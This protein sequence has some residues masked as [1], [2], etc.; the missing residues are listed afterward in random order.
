MHAEGDGGGGE[1]VSKS[2]VADHEELNIELAEEDDPEPEV[3]EWSLEDVELA[4][5]GL[6]LLILLSNGAGLDVSNFG[7]L[8]E[9]SA[10]DHVEEVHHDEDLEHQ[11]LVHHSV[12][13]NV[14]VLHLGGKEV[15]GDI[16]HG[17][18]TVEH[19]DHDDE[20]VDT[21]GKD[22]AHH[23]LG[24]KLIGGLDTVS[25]DFSGMGVLS[26]ESDSGEHIH[27]K[28]DPEE[29]NNVEG[30]VTEDKGRGENEAHAGE[31]DS[32]LELNELANVVLDVTA[33]TDGGDNGVEVIVHKNDIGMILGGGA[34]ILTH[35]ESDV[36]LRESA[37]VGE[38][39]TGNTDGGVAL[40]ESADEHVLQLGGSSV[41][42]NDVVLHFLKAGL[43]LLVSEGESLTTALFSVFDLN[44]K[45]F[46]LSEE[47]VG[48]HADGVV[49]EVIGETESLGS[50]HDVHLVVTRDNSDVGL[51]VVELFDGVI[52]II[53]EGV[54]E[55]KGADKGQIG[56]DDGTGIFI[57][58]V[59]V[60]VLHA[61]EVGLVEV[62]VS[63]SE[64]LEAGVHL[65]VFIILVG[66]DKLVLDLLEVSG[67]IGALTVERSSL[68][69]IVHVGA[70]HLGDEFG[71]TLDNKTDGLGVFL[72]SVSDSH[73]L[74]VRAEGNPKHELLRVFA[75]NK[76][77]LDVNV[78]GKK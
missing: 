23:R 2:G 49:I 60:S 22:G 56:F 66:K 32:H 9:N 14:V 37:G 15:V 16:E 54:L 72:K 25:T 47:I 30:R 26:S 78:V 61:F 74:A 35:G 8:V 17:G 70:A 50:A 1:K 62:S 24:D 51:G 67:T 69:E 77:I 27:D 68:L 11:S 10:V 18:A 43:A 36:G 6:G 76:L 38:T 64:R 59:E 33:P 71:G 28:I 20:L 31:V 46:E 40:T 34:A 57:F 55:R 3:L 7:H 13:G 5:G 4:L 45:V 21:L 19:D 53:S 52:D 63:N 12:G 75:L 39:L 29:L 65:G 42:K 48:G 58:E 73:S 41:D 44:H